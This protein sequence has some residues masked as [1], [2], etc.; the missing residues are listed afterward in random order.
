MLG[1]TH[2]QLQLAWLDHSALSA[3]FDA[4]AFERAPSHVTVKQRQAGL[5][6]RLAMH[7]GYGLSENVELALAAAFGVRRNRTEL[8]F[9]GSSGS[10]STKSKTVEILPSLRYVADGV[11][12]RWYAGGAL[13]F[14]K[15]EVTSPGEF[16]SVMKAFVGSFQFGIYCFV[17]DA[18]S[19]DPGL[20]LSYL[21]PT[22]R[23]RAAE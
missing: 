15:S 13:G 11:D 16:G 2:L 14:L 23:G 12:N 10:S 7:L 17:R 19:I 5:V 8:E 22:V 3:D 6:A 21:L 9:E 18:L 20:E 1:K 4:D